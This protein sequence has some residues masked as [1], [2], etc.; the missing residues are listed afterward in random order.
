M[1]LEE[2]ILDVVR[3]LPFEKQQEILSHANRLRDEARPPKPFRSIRGLLSGRGISISAADID[4]V[5][6]AMWNNFPSKDI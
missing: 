4:E 3:S 2:A 5:R 1:T 6:S